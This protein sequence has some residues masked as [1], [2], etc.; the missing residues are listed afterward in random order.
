MVPLSALDSD[1]LSRCEP[2]AAT[3]E[4]PEEQL[5]SEDGAASASAYASSATCNPSQPPIVTKDHLNKGLRWTTTG[6]L[7]QQL[8]AAQTDLKRLQQTHDAALTRHE[9]ETHAA[10]LA[11]SNELS[12]VIVSMA[13]E[14]MGA[15]GDAA[16]L[17]ERLA[18]KH[19][20]AERAA[21]TIA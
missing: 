17:R 9:R 6:S 7:L 3:T 11:A 8:S 4:P 19:G 18:Q 10:K 16:Q 20:E 1:R 13:L 15:E 14:L 2:L 21:K 5:Q 12:T